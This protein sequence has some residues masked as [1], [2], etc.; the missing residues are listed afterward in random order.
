MVPWPSY[1]RGRLQDLIEEETPHQ[2][3]RDRDGPDRLGDGHSVVIGIAC[4]RE[5][6]REVDY[7]G[8]LQ[9]GLITNRPSGGS[10]VVRSAVDGFGRVRAMAVA[11][12][13]LLPCRG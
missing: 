6:E 7:A 1:R 5:R 12:K 9:S 2:H 10:S 3:G 11:I 8:R 13:V 4:T